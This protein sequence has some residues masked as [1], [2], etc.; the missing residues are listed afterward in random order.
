MKSYYCKRLYEEINFDAENVY[1]CCGKSLGPSFETPQ[2]KCTHNTTI[3]INKYCNKLIDWKLSSARKAYIGNVS[4]NCKNCIELEERE[5]TTSDFLLMKIFPN[6]K[7]KKFKIKN[8]IVKSFRQCE[9]S[10]IYCLE[11]RYTQGKKVKIKTKSDF[12]NLLPIFDALTNQNLLD[13]KEL[14]IEFQGGSISVWDEFLPMLNKI[15]DLGINN[16]MYHTNAVTFIPEIAELARTTNSTMSISIDC[17]CKESYK[18]IK[19]D[20]LFD[21]V[22]ENIIKYENAGISISVKYIIVRNLN[23]N[24][25]EINKF[26]NLMKEIRTNAKN[27]DNISIMFDIDFRESLAENKYIIPDD[28]K[29]LLYHSINF[30][31]ENNFEIGFQEFIRNQLSDI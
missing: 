25:E 2:K 18:K 20:D 26:L 17:G 13:K 29:K 30:G 11:R 24:L 19:G 4:E 3:N 16:V 12:Y 31:K 14:R 1:V 15:K 23:D 27:K 9:L 10:C 7:T 22:I 21:N 6:L 5:I 28:Y 8:I